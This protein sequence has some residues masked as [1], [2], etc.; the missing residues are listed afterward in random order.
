VSY[1]PKF[2]YEAIMMTAEARL[3]GETPPAT[4]IIPSVP[5]QPDNSAGAE[6]RMTS[7]GV[8]TVP[9]AGSRS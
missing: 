2:I 1:S 3:K 8:R 6:V 4:T 5:I 7:D 9:R